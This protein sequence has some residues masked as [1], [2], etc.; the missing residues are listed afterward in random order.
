MHEGES[1][2]R[3]LLSNL[4]TAPYIY[5]VWSAYNIEI[6]RPWFS[7]QRK[8]ADGA[9]DTVMSR[10]YHTRERAKYFQRDYT[11]PAYHFLCPVVSPLVAEVR[12]RTVRAKKSLLVFLRA[13]PTTYRVADL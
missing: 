4:L 2:L 10:S 7:R 11:Y 13:L 9:A 12:H 3:N 5:Q 1:P 6:T 8:D